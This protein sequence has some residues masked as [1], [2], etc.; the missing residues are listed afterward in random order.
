VSSEVDRTG[1]RAHVL[2]TSS[3]VTTRPPLRWHPVVEVNEEALR[4]ARVTRRH[5][6]VTW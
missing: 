4:H 1:P 2:M 6:R 5:F 3:W